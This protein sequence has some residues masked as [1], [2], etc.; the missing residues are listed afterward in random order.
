MRPSTFCLLLCSWAPSGARLTD[1]SDGKAAPRSTLP[2][3]VPFPWLVFAAGLPGI[4]AARCTPGVRPLH[5]AWYQEQTVW[6]RLLKST[7]AFDLL[8]R[9]ESASPPQPA[10]PPATLL[11]VYV[12]LPLDTVWPVERDGRK[13][14]SGFGAPLDTLMF[15]GHP[16]LLSGGGVVVFSYIKTHLALQACH[17]R[18]HS[19]ACRACGNRLGKR[20]WR[21]S[22]SC[23]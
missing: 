9:R 14:R 10:P 2:F 6:R 18:R 17:L 12:M 5:S 8:E 16:R 23:P 19:A 11:P 13:V 3:L 20:P 4:G 7:Q 22:A 21:R 15:A 1:S